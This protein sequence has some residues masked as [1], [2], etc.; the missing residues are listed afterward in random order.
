MVASNPARLW[1]WVAVGVVLL[2]AGAGLGWFVRGSPNRGGT[3]A[4][5]KSL[6]PV[7]VPTPTGSLRVSPAVRAQER[8]ERGTTK[9]RAVLEDALDT[10]TDV[11]EGAEGGSRQ[12]RAQVFAEAAAEMR[13]LQ[14]RLEG[15]SILDRPAKLQLASSLLSESLETT[16]VALAQL[17]AALSSGGSAPGVTVQL[18]EAARLGNEASTQLGRVDCRGIG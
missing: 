2:L 17:S 15:L 18:Q 4:P 12:E 10:W 11:F 9:L 6:T 7:M 1:A 14:V 8:C 13:V 3:T 16:E 5:A